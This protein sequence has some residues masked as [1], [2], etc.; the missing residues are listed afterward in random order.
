MEDLHLKLGFAGLNTQYQQSKFP[1][2]FISKA[3]LT[4][5]LSDISLLWVYTET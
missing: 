3:L 5:Q 4:V 1:I 2:Y